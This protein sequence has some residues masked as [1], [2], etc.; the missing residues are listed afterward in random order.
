MD[1]DKK[2]QS[3]SEVEVKELSEI[4]TVHLENTDLDLHKT[5]TVHLE[6][7]VKELHSNIRHITQLGMTWFAFFVTTNY[8]TLGWFAQV[9]SEEG[10]KI[11]PLI[12]GMVSFVFIVQNALGI[13]GIYKVKNTAKAKA[14]QV[15]IYESWLLIIYK[16]WLKST[17]TESH[18][19]VLERPSIPGKLYE[20]I[21]LTLMIVLGSLI[22]A[23][24][25]TWRNY[26]QK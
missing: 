20:C 25:I 4:S 8:V 23:W 1:C 18:V 14:T 5:L 11:N 16:N 21:A 24:I 9:P 6:N 26:V 22:V 3:N 13:F 19:K 2:Q 12:I 7:K 10:K 17:N 15:S